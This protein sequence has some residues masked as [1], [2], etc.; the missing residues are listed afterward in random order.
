MAFTV[1][2]LR[3]AAHGRELVASAVDLEAALRAAEF[4]RPR[5]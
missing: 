2:G 1:V 4:D 3:V 5:P